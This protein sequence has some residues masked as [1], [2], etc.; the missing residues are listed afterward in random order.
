MCVAA[1]VVNYDHARSVATHVLTAKST[2]VQGYVS[3]MHKAQQ[4]AETA[5]DMYGQNHMVLGEPL[6]YLAQH[7][8]TEK[9]V[10][11]LTCPWRSA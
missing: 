9:V 4:A 8:G 5:L 7:A 11:E 3:K 1:P 2:E 6:L 10:H